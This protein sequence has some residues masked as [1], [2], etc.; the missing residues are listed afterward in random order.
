MAKKVFGLASL[1]IADI[2]SDGGMGTA[3][4]TVGETVSGTCVMAQ[5]DNTTTDFTIEESSSPIESITSAEGKIT[6]AWSSY[7]VS[8]YQLKKLFGGTG[9]YK[10]VAGTILTLGSIT[11]GTGYTNGFYEKVTLTG[12]AGSGAIANITVAGGVVNTV[13]VID[14]GSGYA[15]ANNLSATAA[16]IG[17]TGSGFQ[18]PVATVASTA[19]S[20]SWSAPDSFPDIEKSIEVIDGKGNKLVIPRAKIASKMGLSFAKD[21]LGQLDMVATILQPNKVSEKRLTITLAP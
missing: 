2:A 18:V 8:T 6:L 14:G 20:E 15:A 16:S 17:G 10:Q 4:T 13:E 5:E 1:K 21:K 12:G 9:N 7:N 19:T 3:L 11:A